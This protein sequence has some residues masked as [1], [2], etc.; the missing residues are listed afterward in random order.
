MWHKMDHVN[1][2]NGGSLADHWHAGVKGMGD[3]GKGD[4]IGS[5]FT[6]IADQNRAN[7]TPVGDAGAVE[8]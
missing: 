5:V 7:I 6:I 4:V 2:L 8:R 1:C 3:K